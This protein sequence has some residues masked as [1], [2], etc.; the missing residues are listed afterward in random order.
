MYISRCFSIIILIKYTTFIYLPIAHYIVYLVSLGVVAPLC[1]EP[2]EVPYSTVTITGF[3][4]GDIAF[5]TCDP[6]Y[7]ILNGIH[8]ELMSNNAQSKCILNLAN[9]TEAVWDY[10]PKCD[11]M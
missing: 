8:S 11:G 1:P 5:Y 9:E 7:M 4:P 2:P 3:Y 10:V 6:G